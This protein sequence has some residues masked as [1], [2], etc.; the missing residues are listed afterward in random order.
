M[1]AGYLMIGSASFLG[2]NPVRS[3]R[4]P[5]GSLR[6]VRTILVQPPRRRAP[7]P[8]SGVFRETFGRVC[9]GGLVVSWCAH[10]S[11]EQSRNLKCFGSPSEHAEIG[12]EPFGIVVRRLVGTVLDIFC[13]VWRRFKPTSG[14]KSNIPGRM[15][16]N[17]R[18]PFKSAEKS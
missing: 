3:R 16:K 17:V 4:F 5:A 2:A 15:F 10:D 6:V 12:P 18:G 14:L 11:V 7:S 9:S 1:C 8:A 13:L